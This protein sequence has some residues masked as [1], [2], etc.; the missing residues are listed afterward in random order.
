VVGT[1]F[2]LGIL[3]TPA[4]VPAAMLELAKLLRSPMHLALQRYANILFSCALAQHPWYAYQLSTGDASTGM[5][6][7][8][9]SSYRRTPHWSGAATHGMVRPKAFITTAS[10]SPREQPSQP[11]VIM[12]PVLSR[13]VCMH[14][15]NQSMSCTLC[16]WRRGSRGKVNSSITGMQH[17]TQKATSMM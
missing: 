12:R 5:H 4:R 10:P 17:K 7:L 1:S 15:I 3:H 2:H 14:S 16:E 9:R 11:P 13:T 6:T 8:L